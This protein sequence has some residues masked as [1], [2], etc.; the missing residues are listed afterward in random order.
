M[1]IVLAVGQISGSFNS[2]G[3]TIP[4]NTMKSKTPT[5]HGHSGN[6]KNWIVSFRPP[7]H[8]RAERVAM[9]INVEWST[10]P[11]VTQKAAFEFA[12]KCEIHG[13]EVTLRSI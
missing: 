12:A 13:D 11:P 4:Q 5:K 1:Q 2:S 10:S 8:E 9:G 6:K 7:A 3:E